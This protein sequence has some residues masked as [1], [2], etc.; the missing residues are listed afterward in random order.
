[1]IVGIGTD[2]AEIA[3]IRGLLAKTEKFKERNFTSAEREAGD[4]RKDAAP[5]YA[6]R[7]AAKEACAKALGCGIGAECALTDEEITNDANNA[8]RLTLPG[9]AAKRAAKLGV[10][11]CHVSITHEQEYAAAFV[12]LEK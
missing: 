11:A 5:Y 1:M 12:I 6:G 7:W 4:L 9:A 8:P 10:N 2:L 3:R